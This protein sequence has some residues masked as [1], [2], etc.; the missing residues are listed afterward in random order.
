MRRAAL[1]LLLTLAGVAAA[2]DDPSGRGDERPWKL[3]SGVYTLSGGGEPSAQALDLN[4]RRSGDFGNAWIGWYGQDH[5]GRQ[6]TVNE[7]KP[8]EDRPRS[9]GGGGGGGGGRS[10]GGGG[11]GRPR[12]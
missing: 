12:Y 3:T 7:A 9:G 1:L 10:S 6:L 8:R 5:G 2:A 11:G 4:L